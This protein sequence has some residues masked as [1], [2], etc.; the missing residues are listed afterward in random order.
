MTVIN[1]L[2]TT[3]TPEKKTELAK[4]WLK[5]T[6]IEISAMPL[7]EGL[8]KNAIIGK[9]RRM[10]LPQKIASP[11]QCKISKPKPKRKQK[12]T[13]RPDNLPTVP[14]ENLGK[15][16]KWP[17]GDPKDRD[18][19]FC[20]QPVVEEKPYCEEHCQKAYLPP[21]KRKKK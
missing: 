15:G 19:G 13:P 12:I 3:W 2:N 10:N 4:L 17:Y 8:S 9:A 18:F 1:H 20:G 6:A 7:F 21:K 5:H 14:L 16:C 11:G